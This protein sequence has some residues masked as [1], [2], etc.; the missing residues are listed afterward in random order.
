[1]YQDDEVA[2]AGRASSLIDEIARLEHQKVTHTATEQRLEAAKR[3]LATLQ[4]PT[5]ARTR[6]PGLLAHVIVFGATAGTAYLGYT[7]LL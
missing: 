6:A 5:P 1:M 7:L 3:E 4:A 2:R